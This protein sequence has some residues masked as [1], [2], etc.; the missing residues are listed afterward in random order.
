MLF[1]LKVSDIIVNVNTI[2][3]NF[4]SEKIYRK[5]SGSDLEVIS[6]KMKLDVGRILHVLELDFKFQEE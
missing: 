4:V 5:M 6:S 1:I 3:Y 2:I